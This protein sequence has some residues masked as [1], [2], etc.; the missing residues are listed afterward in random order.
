MKFERR[1]IPADKIAEADAGNTAF[2]EVADA[3]GKRLGYLRDFVGPVSTHGACACDPINVTLAFDP[4]GKFFTFISPAPLTKWDHEPMTNE[5]TQRLIG[6]LHDPPAQLLEVREVEDLVDATTGATKPEYA[7]FVVH[8]AAL[9]TRRLVQIVED[10]EGIIS[11]APEADDKRELDSITS[12]LDGVPRMHAL[13]AYMGRVNSPEVGQR[14]YVIMGRDYLHALQTGGSLDEQVNARLLDS[15]LVE[16]IGPGLQADICYRLAQERAALTVAER[17]ALQLEKYADAAPVVSLIRGTV[18]FL[19]GDMK[20]SIPELDKAAWRFDV[21]TEPRLHA[22]LATAL[23]STSQLEPGCNKALLLHRANPLMSETRML[24]NQC[25][26]ADRNFTTKRVAQEK[27][28]H[29][30]LLGLKQDGKKV[31]TIEVDNA[32]LVPVRLDAAD[33]KRVTVMMYFATWCPHCQAE[34][35]KVSTFADNIASNPKLRGRVRVI[36]VRTATERETETIDAFR[37]R[38][39][40]SFPIYTDT[41]MSIGYSLVVQETGIAAGF[42]TL[43]VLDKAGHIRYEMPSGEFRDTNRELEW[44]VTSLLD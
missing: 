2:F 22:R 10:T 34:L 3:D 43:L 27:E 44:A 26:T 23:V 7:E 1:S 6:I 36:G 19:R 21:K 24:I 4:S 33:A 29:K 20:G 42:P 16:R 41:A 39:P 35:P 17:C 15:T 8:R 37:A 9:E 38:I 40:M 32:Q 30:M 5:E 28:D 14:A 11:G 31:P 18:M 25:A 13:A 12:K